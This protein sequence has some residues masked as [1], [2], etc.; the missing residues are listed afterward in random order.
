MILA[1][2]LLS[3][4]RTSFSLNTLF[5]IWKH[6]GLLELVSIF[7]FVLCRRF[8]VYLL[9]LFL[10]LVFITFFFNHLLIIFHIFLILNLFD[11]RFFEISTLH[12]KNTRNK[13]NEKKSYNCTIYFNNSAYTYLKQANQQANYDWYYYVNQLIRINWSLR[14]LFYR[15]YSEQSFSN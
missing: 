1:I 9:L 4:W 15:K 6:Y 12:M 8:I 14:R 3:I 11:Y 5:Q 10:I 7:F 13:I 2:L